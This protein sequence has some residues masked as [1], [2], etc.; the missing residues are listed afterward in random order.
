MI[1]KLMVRSFMHQLFHH[2]H[3]RVQDATTQQKNTHQDKSAGQAVVNLNFNLFMMASVCI[4]KIE[5]QP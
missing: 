3:P 4:I 5:N 2:S 1:I